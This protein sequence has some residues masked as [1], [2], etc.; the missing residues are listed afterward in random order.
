MILNSP[1]NS[2]YFDLSIFLVFLGSSR[3]TSTCYS[4]TGH[5]CFVLPT[6]KL[7][8]EKLTDSQLVNKFP[9]FYGTR[10]LITA[11]SVARHLH[12]S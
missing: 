1:R 11:L 5:E 4:K 2:R 12:V 8:G 6:S 9:T 10:R 3:R 7:N